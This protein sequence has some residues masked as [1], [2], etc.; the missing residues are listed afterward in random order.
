MARE[1]VGFCL[2]LPS[3]WLFHPAC[4]ARVRRVASH[5]CGGGL[6]TRETGCFARVRRDASHACGGNTAR[7]R[8]NPDRADP[9]RRGR[10]RPGLRLRTMPQTEEKIGRAMALKCVPTALYL[11]LCTPSSG[12]M[13]DYRKKLNDYFLSKVLFIPTFAYHKLLR[14]NCGRNVIL[15]KKLLYHE[16][17]TKKQRIGQGA[18]PIAGYGLSYR[19]HLGIFVSMECPCGIH[20][21]A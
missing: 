20:A 18:E 15:L 2:S 21:G 1:S 3:G 19:G 10:A 14:N 16:N 7:V 17:R 9:F 8:Q 11:F 12:I 6:F 5:A 4:F 13:T